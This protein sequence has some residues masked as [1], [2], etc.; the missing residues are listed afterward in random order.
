M[1]G[2]ATLTWSQWGTPLLSRHKQWR[3]RLWSRTSRSWPAR[4]LGQTALEER[5]R[6]S[7][8]NIKQENQ[9]ISQLPKPES[10]LL[11]GVNVPVWTLH[12]EVYRYMSV[13]LSYRWGWR[14]SA[15]R[16][17]HPQPGKLAGRSCESG[18]G[19]AGW[20]CVQASP[21]G[22][23]SSGSDRCSFQ[24]QRCWETGRSTPARWQTWD[25][26]TKVEM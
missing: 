3:E 26:R 25:R 14:W 11:A 24:S 9:L 15:G 5:T 7:E 10:P 23:R 21:P 16:P 18:W 2:S 13:C 22:R 4:F 20:W 12:E 8:G 1:Y 17:C 19:W 6:E